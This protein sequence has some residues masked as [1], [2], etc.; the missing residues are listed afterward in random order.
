MQWH[1]VILRCIKCTKANMLNKMLHSR[2]IAMFLC[3]HFA[4]VHLV[5][6]WNSHDE[7]NCN[8]HFLSKWNT[9]YRRMD[10]TH[11]R[12][13]NQESMHIPEQCN[14]LHSLM[15]QRGKKNLLIHMF[16]SI[17]IE[18]HRML[19]VYNLSNQCNKL[20]SRKVANWYYIR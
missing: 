9:F 20:N 11:F 5:K 7:K 8:S 13:F 2:K 10:L 17:C 14:E 18:L 19:N 6:W 12:H 15:A 3:A 1:D 16:T 4:F